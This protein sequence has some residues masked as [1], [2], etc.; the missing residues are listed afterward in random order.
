MANG[1]HPGL[2]QSLGIERRIVS[3]AH[4]T[5]IGFDVKPVGRAGFA[6]KA[7]TY[8]PEKAADGVAYMSI[9]PAGGVNRVN[10]FTYWKP[11]DARLEG[12]HTAPEQTLHRLWPRLNRVLGNFAVENVRIRPIDLY[13]TQGFEQPGIVLVGDAFCTACPA[14]G[15]GAN[16]VFTDVVQ[17]CTEHIPQWMASPGMA[18]EKLASFYADPVK[19]AC[20]EDSATRAFHLRSLS[21]DESLG[22]CAKRLARFGAQAGLSTLTWA[23][24]FGTELSGSV[25]LF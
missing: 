21:T 10:L 13:V 20:D 24:S 8:Y 5:A 18:A 11:R 6:F 14:V 25:P 7:L 3:R 17:L 16:K 1:L 9:F 2:A 15:V 19:R 4:T 23:L 12:M 22:W